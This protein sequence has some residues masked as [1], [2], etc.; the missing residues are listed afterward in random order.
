MV[1]QENKQVGTDNVE[2]DVKKPKKETQQ[3]IKARKYEEKL[4]GLGNTLDRESNGKQVQ[5]V[6]KY[7]GKPGLDIKEGKYRVAGTISASPLFQRKGAGTNIAYSCGYA[8]EELSTGKVMYVTKEQGVHIAS[9]HGMQNAYIQY[10]VGQK[11]D[12]EGK[13]IKEKTSIYLQPFPPQK[14]SFTQDDRLVSVFKLD[15]EGK[16]EQPYELAITDESKCTPEFWIFIQEL[17]KQKQKRNKKR[18]R[19]RGSED[20]HRQR[21]LGIEAELSKTEIRNPFE[22]M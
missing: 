5:I 3:E 22:E 20:K 14:E 1:E 6:N 11:K 10:K 17:N 21:I 7:P 2:T 16:I 12:K 13:V 9:Q 4:E 15:D 18:K 8:I 19:N